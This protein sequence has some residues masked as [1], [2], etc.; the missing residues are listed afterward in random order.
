MAIGPVTENTRDLSPFAALLDYV[1]NIPKV[2][3]KFVAT[4]MLMGKLRVA[5]TWCRGHSPQYLDWV[6]DLSLC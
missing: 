4:A 1:K 3:R 6:I 2:Y 5:I